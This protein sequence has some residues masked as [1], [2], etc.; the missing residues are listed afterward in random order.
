[1][2]DLAVLGLEIRSDS[3][4][5]AGKRLDDF[6]RQAVRTDRTAD[7]V[8]K[9]I[10]RMAAQFAALAA[11][12][13]S[14]NTMIREARAFDA[15][16]A[17]VSTLLPVVEGEIDA[18]AEA[19]RRMS[20]EFGTTAASQAQA[21]YQA[22]SAGAGDAAQATELLE[23]ANRT[24]IGGIT[25]VTV[26]VD[27]LTTATNAYAAS[28]LTASDA[29]DTL[30]V[31]MRA[32]KTTID[33]LASTLGRVIPQA[34]AV[35]LS[36][37]EIVAATA[38]LTT[39]GQS[40]EMAVTGLSGIMTQLLKPSSQAVDL[41]KELGI[42]F[43]ATAAQTMGLAGFMEY[44]VEATGGSQEALAM[45]FGST[46]ALRAVF[47][48]AGQGGEKF[49]DILG[50]MEERAGAA[51]EAFNR[52]SES[53][54]QRLN[55]VMARFGDHALGAGQV[56]LSVMVPALEL[57]A[58]AA[59][60]LAANMER[61]V[62]YL[63]VAAVAGAIAFRGAIAAAAA[64]TWGFVSALVATRAALIRTGLGA[65]VV[66]LGELV[67]QLWEAIDRAG[68]FGSA[69]QAAGRTAN[70]A[71]ESIKN[72]A[73]AMD[74]AL[75]GVA[76]S[77]EAAFRT[78]WGNILVGFEN[79]MSA[80]TGRAPETYGAIA[81]PGN[82]QLSEADRAR[83][84]AER[85][86]GYSAHYWDLAMNGTP[87]PNVPG[88]P[89]QRGGRGGSSSVT[90]R[91]PGVGGSLGA[92][93]GGGGAE[94]QLNAYEQATQAVRDNI[95]ALERQ[96]QAFG[97]SETAA[98][99]FNTAMDLLKGAQEAGIP[100]T[101]ELIGEINALADAYAVAEERSRM[102][103]QQQELAQSINDTLASGFS[104]MFTGIINGS[105]SAGDAI[106]DLISSLGQ[107]LINQ[108]F[109]AL[110]GGGT[111]GGIGG[112]L[113]GL[114][115][116]NAFGNVYNSPGLSAY[117]GQVVSSPTFFPFANGIGLMGEAGPEAIMPLRRGPDGRLG[118]AANGNGAGSGSVLTVR[119]V[120]DS[121]KEVAQ[122]KVQDGSAQSLDVTL[123]Q[124]VARKIASP[125]SETSRAL[126]QRY[127]LNGRLASR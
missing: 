21:F 41:A 66:V 15:A 36:F 1:M 86:F 26:A 65:L 4:P 20:R 108:A 5:V 68:G 16:L 59:D 114:F 7:R 93:G 79:M 95:E 43:S 116:P 71:I 101:D 63:G 100:V 123:D 55:V 51:D 29:A 107:L 88:S 46:E 73:T 3:V 109:T 113:S 39:Q 27:I 78:A 13:F 64:A 38:A 122:A 106:R 74:R 105:K 80:I 92:L 67:Y 40:T 83:A 90:P 62:S 34:T 32:G 125:G 25:Q 98:A 45:L 44:L 48:L 53:L 91:V 84:S 82:L 77:V 23:V 111:S 112:F 24:A 76:Y 85:E 102:L 70:R 17:E 28:G 33:E 60:I 75:R 118:V 120:D 6:E 56:L 57:L 54:D 127:G 99:R 110:F 22:I 31:G 12:T 117:S 49:N 37:D 87:E 72:G 121:G 103:Q 19:S 119:F 8:A 10:G 42:E 61:L 11:V 126:Q 47:S 124:I 94:A 81:S 52:V 97:L 58:G 69:M 2:A 104:N 9:T 96:Q 50:D 14:F 18:I 89:G 35:G 30:F 115:V